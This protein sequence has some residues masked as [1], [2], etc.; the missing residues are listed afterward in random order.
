MREALRVLRPGGR[1][2]LLEHVLSEKPILRQLMRFLDPIPFH[3]WGAH[4]A[5]ETVKVVNEAGFVDQATE[6]KSLDVVKLIEAKA[7]PARTG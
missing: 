6:N 2:V 1:L 3:M 5:R 4:I 7:P